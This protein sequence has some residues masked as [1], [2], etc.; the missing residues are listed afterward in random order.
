MLKRINKTFIAL[1][2]KTPTPKS[3]LD[4]RPISL[5]NTVYKI[6]A[7]VTVNRIKPFLQKIIGTPQKG[8]VPRR[9]IQ[10]A[11]I[12]THEIIHSMEKNK[13]PSMALKLDISNVYDKVRWDFLYDVLERVGC[14]E[15]VLNL[16][17]TMVSIVQY[18][19]L[20]NGSP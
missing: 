16:I 12:T 19:V 18:V 6:F 15:K 20:L 11:V 17:R 8:F 9:Q 2:P 14:N 1:V 13:I 4:F 7:K 10:D 5:C 3:L